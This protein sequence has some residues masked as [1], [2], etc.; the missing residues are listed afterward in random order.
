MNTTEKA[1]LQDDCVGI[2]TVGEASSQ[3][4]EN[5]H[6]RFDPDNGIFV[7][8]EARS[9]DEAEEL[10]RMEEGLLAELSR[11]MVEVLHGHLS[12]YLGSR[13]QQQKIKSR[14]PDFINFIL[15]SILGTDPIVIDSALHSQA[16]SP[17][18]GTDGP[19]KVPRNIAVLSDRE[20][21]LSSRFSA[22]ELHGGL[23][24]VSVNLEVAVFFEGGVHIA[25]R[26][27]SQQYLMS[28]KIKKVT[29][30]YH[31]GGLLS[32][33][34]GTAD[35]LPKIDH[36][37]LKMKRGDRLVILS[38][39]LF[40]TGY[41]NLRVLLGDNKQTPEKS[42]AQIVRNLSRHKPEN[43][44]VFVIDPQ[45]KKPK[46]QSLFGGFATQ[47]LG[48]SG[49]SSAQPAESPGPLGLSQAQGAESPGTPDRSKT[50]TI[51]SFGGAL[52]ETK[53][54][55]AFAPTIAQAADAAPHSPAKS[56]LE[57]RGKEK[58][59]GTRKGRGAE[60][61]TTLTEEELSRIRTKLFEKI[62]FEM[63]GLEKEMSDVIEKKI[64][65]MEDRIY[66]RLSERGEAA[67]VPSGDNERGGSPARTDFSL[68]V[69]SGRGLDSGGSA[70]TADPNQTYEIN[71]E[72][73]Y[74]VVDGPPE[75]PVP[76]PPPES[77]E[78]STENEENTLVLDKELGT[79]LQ[80]NH[81]IY[82]LMMLFH[83]VKEM[84]K[85][86]RKSGG[87]G[88]DE[89][90]SSQGRGLRE[91]GL[92]LRA[93]LQVFFRAVV[94]HL[95]RFT[96]RSELGKA[97]SKKRLIFV[98][99]LVG[100]AFIGLFFG[101]LVGRSG[102]DGEEEGA[103]NANASPLTP[104]KGDL[105]S[106]SSKRASSEKVPSGSS[107]PSASNADDTPEKVE[108]I[109]P[110]SDTLY[111]LGKADTIEENYN[112][113]R[114]LYRE[115]D[116]GR[117]IDGTKIND[118]NRIER[119][120]YA[121]AYFEKALSLHN[122]KGTEDP[123]LWFLKARTEY[124]LAKLDFERGT[125]AEKAMESYRTYKKLVGWPPKKKRKAMVRNMQ[126]LQKWQ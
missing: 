100:A 54:D 112:L 62:E 7:F 90:V 81:L 4:L 60:R 50:K 53:S 2:A 45:F 29:E 67:Y 92:R 52:S 105:D 26:G 43:G 121:L 8:A 73:E 65:E 16:M 103:S 37:S 30:D 98:C 25:H 10:T 18:A 17:R 87:Q 14:H 66:R 108:S 68:G 85:L 46:S 84:L 31:T 42:A 111:F 49:P 102:G 24:N 104:V 72:S 126:R 122:A 97:S 115:G 93:F 110:E 39:G 117:K 59:H 94:R 12:N 38:Q 82:R 6:Y 123:D 95:E 125:Y 28:Q 21:E 89:S 118:T 47:S 35:F 106:V 19:H 51:A 23:P 3:T 77:K 34:S 15:Q 88:N 13:N 41:P 22:V 80:K 86:L 74:E 79:D 83:R 101:M 11:T 32:A 44:Y 109:S 58:L 63:I 48:T 5:Q 40:P 91:K 70:A 107:D 116:R 71:D 61:Q 9:M 119:L 57:R 27:S 78:L 55:T 113:G 69:S 64:L 76:P 120:R 33:L 1:V 99:V 36:K 20:K 124:V 75:T 114:R 96:G 56:P